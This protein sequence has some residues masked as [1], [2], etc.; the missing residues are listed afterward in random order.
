MYNVKKHEN[1]SMETRDFHRS[2]IAFLI[3][4]GNI[5]LLKDSGMSHYEWAKSLGVSDKDFSNIVRGYFLNKVI[6]FYKGNFR[7]DEEVI[8]IA[9][10]Y[11]LKIKELCNIKETCSVYC[12]VIIGEAGEVWPP[13][14]F[15]E[16]I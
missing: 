15:I 11:G 7:Y 14:L 8:S 9:K 3:I 4:D 12:G 6:V 10:E 2:R 16:E 5:H 1:Y 13:E